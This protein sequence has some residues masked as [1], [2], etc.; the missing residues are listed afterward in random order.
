MTTWVVDA[1]VAI[2]WFVPEIHSSHARQ[3]LIEDN[4]LLAPELL[5]AEVGNILWKKH[6][7]GELE[8]VEA[9]D[10]LADLRRLPLRLIPMSTTIESALA[11]AVQYERTVYDSVY[12]SLAIHQG[13]RFVTADRKLFNALIDTDI[14]N[15][16][17]WIEDI[18]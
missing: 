2:K 6:R 14:A 15:N 1:S 8:A 4:E 7:I 5:I 18:F 3:L 10:I 9:R 17:A 12:L 16:I 13:V 11:L